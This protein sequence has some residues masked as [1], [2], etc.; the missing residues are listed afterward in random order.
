MNDLMIRLLEKLD[1]LLALILL[2]LIGASVY[3]VRE[4]RSLTSQLNQQERDFSKALSQQ[5]REYAKAVLV[6]GKRYHENVQSLIRLL[7]S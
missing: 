5:E 7:K 3:L 4:N 2:L 1:P 6:L